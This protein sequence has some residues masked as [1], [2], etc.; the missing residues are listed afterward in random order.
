M[1]RV[2]VGCRRKTDGIVNGLMDKSVVHQ[3]DVYKSPLCPRVK[4]LASV[5]AL[6][7]LPTLYYMKALLHNLNPVLLILNESIP[8]ISSSLVLDSVD[9]M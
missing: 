3:L 2:L 9:L 1:D 8:V 5:K 4:T 6:C 7:R